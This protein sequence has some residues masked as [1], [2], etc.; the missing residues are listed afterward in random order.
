MKPVHPFV[1]EKIPDIAVVCRRHRVKR[2]EVFGSATGEAFDP[3]TSDI[4]F[5]V[6]FE[7]MPPPEHAESYFGLA[8]DLEALFGRPVDLIEPSAIRNPFFRQAVEENE[9]LVYAAA[10]EQYIAPRIRQADSGR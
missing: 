8:E 2:L 10:G 4:D 9:V 7:R 5:I 1:E 3:T 6:E